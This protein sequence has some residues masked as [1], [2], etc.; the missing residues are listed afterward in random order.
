MSTS[1]PTIRH[2]PANTQGRDFVVGDLHGCRRELDQALDAVRFDRAID[3]LFSVGDLV[4]RGPDSVAC[5]K[6][7]DE[8][9]FHPIQGNHE[10]M[11]ATWLDAPPRSPEA[12]FAAMQALDNGARAWATDYL[13]FR[14]A[15]P[16][17]LERLMRK[18]GTLPHVLV[19]GDGPARFNIVHAELRCQDRD[20]GVFTDADIDAGLPDALIFD[21]QWSRVIMAPGN[22]KLP[23][24]AAG[25]STTY[26]GHTIDPRVRRR[27]SHVCI[28]TGACVAFKTRSAAHALTLVEHSTGEETRIAAGQAPS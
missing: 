19:V 14:E 27:L 9:W 17:E 16:A 3:R 15:L 28:D 11:L 18:L 12:R 22:D 25:L 8:P 13:L 1:K 20:D 26:C 7:L 23:E 6:L 24:E 2:L 5:L 21:L 10:A 4:D